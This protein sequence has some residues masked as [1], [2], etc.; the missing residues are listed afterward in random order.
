M[1]A[2]DDRIAR[3][4][5]GW[6]ESQMAH[7]FDPKQVHKLD[8][9]ERQKDL[10][11]VETL[12]RL[13]VS[14][15]MT[16]IDLGCGSGYFALPAAELV[17][18]EGRVYALDIHPE[19]VEL[20]Q[21]RAAESGAANLTA[22]LAEEVTIPLPDC[23]ADAVLVV[24]V[25]H[26]FEDLPASLAEMARVLRPQGRL[27]VIDWR[28]EEMEA[29]PPLHARFSEQ[30][31]EEVLARAGFRVVERADPGTLHYGMIAARG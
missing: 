19:L 6:E 7:K 13:G 25:L 17:G 26:E 16:L 28:K 3:M 9:P 1:A 14:E 15:G 24:N 4:E 22:L 23:E 18:P 2:V 27:L 20:C 30:E 21:N 29:G 12:R 5:R 31:A 11:P 10:P 8:D